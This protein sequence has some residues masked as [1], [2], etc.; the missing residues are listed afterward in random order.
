VFPC[1]QF[2]AAL[3]L[4]GFQLVHQFCQGAAA[5][6]T[7]SM[8]CPCSHNLVGGLSLWV[9]QHKLCS[10]VRVSSLTRCRAWRE[11]ELHVLA[12]YALCFGCC[13]CGLRS[14]CP[15]FLSVV[16]L[17]ASVPRYCGYQDSNSLVASGQP[18][19]AAAALRHWNNFY[20]LIVYCQVVCVSCFG[21][22]LGVASCHV[23]SVI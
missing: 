12:Q 9:P 7:C 22:F 13:C 15:A 21:G 5:L 11:L 2:M 14:C 18:S 3:L 8:A 16:L 20:K 10:H 19:V 17:F 6:N 4:C 23:C 1:L